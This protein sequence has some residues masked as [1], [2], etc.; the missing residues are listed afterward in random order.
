MDNCPEQV[1]RML[2]QGLAIE[3]PMGRAA[4][5]CPASSLRTLPMEK[6]MIAVEMMA[7]E[8]VEEII[9]RHKRCM[10]QRETS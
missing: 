10:E 8:L 6:R 1:N 4:G 2:L 3:C 5:D 9:V 7:L